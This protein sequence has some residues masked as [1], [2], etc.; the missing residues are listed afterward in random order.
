MSHFESPL[1]GRT[2]QYSGQSPDIDRLIAGI[3][4][5]NPAYDLEA[6]FKLDRRGIHPA[7]LLV[8]FDTRSSQLERLDPLLEWLQMPAALRGELAKHLGNANKLGF[9]I[10]R[11]DEKT[12]VKVYLEFWEQLRKLV[13]QSED[14]YRPREL[15]T[16]YKWQFEDPQNWRIDR[17]VCYPFL[18]LT[19]IRR[20]IDLVY[21]NESSDGLR[22]SVQRLL[23]ACAAS[24]HPRDA[25]VFTEI[26]EP[27]K[28]RCS[29]DVNL[30]K[31]ALT[32]ADTATEI[33]AIGARLEIA[34]QHL[35]A[36]LQTHSRARLGHLSGGWD[37]N[38]DVFV[39][40][41]YEPDDGRQA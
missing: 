25:F 12:A 18:P 37:A 36:L 19:G 22:L 28:R 23:Q 31:S 2:A 8:A 33:L 9:G 10:D 32:L 24:L 13:Q 29:F 41:Y 30:Y 21:G 1:P 38:G 35:Q 17:Y 14:R 4:P 15:F 39:T 11:Q 7:R 3:A 27:G 40:I 34:G 16:G 5:I 20:R 6:S 26:R